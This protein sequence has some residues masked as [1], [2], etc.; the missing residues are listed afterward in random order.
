MLRELRIDLEFLLTE[1]LDVEDL[2]KRERFA[3]HSLESVLALL[4][5]A[6]RIAAEKFEPFNRLI[7]S[8]PPY[9]RDGAVVQTGAAHE[10]WK[11][12]VDFGILSA[13]Q[14]YGS[15]GVQLPK[16]VESAVN[17]FFAA[18][19]IGMSP[20]GLTSANASLLVAHGS[21]TQRRVFA[22]RELSGEWAGT[23]CLSEPHAGSSLADITTRALSDEG[24]FE[25]P[26][27]PRYRIFGS[28]MWISGGDH[29]LTTNI[30]HLVLA[31][32]P[33]ADGSIAS[34]T[35]GISL[36]IVPK[37]VVDDGGQLI[38]RN[39]VTLIGLNHKLGYRGLPN[40]SL[41][42]GDGSFTPQDKPGAIG[43]RVGEVGQ[44]LRQM[45]HMMNSFRVKVGLGASS[46]G[47]AGYHASL[48][49]ARTRTQGR[50]IGDGGSTSETPQVPIIEHADVK[51]MLLA[52]KSYCEGG[53]A[54]SLFCA[55]L[56]DRI[57]TGVANEVRRS[58][59]L[60]ETLT[61]IVKS[62]PSEWCLEGNNLAIQVHG[63]AGYTSDFP[64][65]QFWRDNR[66]NMIHE[67]T[68][69]IQAMDLLGRKVKLEGGAG[70]REFVNVVSATIAAGRRNHRLSAFA[71]QLDLALS[72]LQAATDGALDTL[73]VAESLANATPYLQGFGHIV[74][75]WIWL[76]VVIRTSSS[77][78]A[79]LPGKFAALKYFFAYELPKIDAWLN[80]ARE[81]NQVC[82]EM[83]DRWF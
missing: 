71:D 23:M 61:P 32:T 77:K 11:S 78:S 28:K 41:S 8:E 12:L 50:R 30:V 75:A 42:F 53:I 3:D 35:Q 46:L 36:F 60:L 25:D 66:L 2:L 72:T 37:F 81:R 24:D 57:K 49:Y 16:T 27:G 48:N 19:A 76:D 31:K 33:N 74:I 38:E 54:L 51:R 44:G 1:W 47:Y 20:A 67:G 55:S 83:E 80:V 18:S 63:G 15:G 73:N 62:W 65:E 10:A 58:S 34:G 82:A 4:Q 26:L 9:V 21:E 68:H 40:A 69:G 6:E 13:V 22:A 59:L 79:L 43:Y 7:D 64:V 45:F 70:Y 39:D 17:T 52:Q 29:G 14:D 56:L 5:M